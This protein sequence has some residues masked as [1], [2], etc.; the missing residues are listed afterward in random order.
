MPV[1]RRLT[2]PFGQLVLVELR[3][4]ET[5]EAFDEASASLLADLPKSASSLRRTN[6]L[7]GRLALMEALRHAGAAPHPIGQSARGAPIVPLGF[8]GSVSHKRL[9]RA[10]GPSVVAAALVAKVEP[11]Q[12]TVGVDLETKAPAR[13]DIASRILTAIEQRGL[14]G[15]EVDWPRV[16]ASFSVKE[17]I[18]KAVDPL[19]QRYVAF[20]EAELTDVPAHWPTPGGAFVRALLA[21]RR[22]EPSFELEAFLQTPA[23]DPDLLVSAVRATRRPH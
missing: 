17:S 5:D 11:G 7:A 3:L 9:R 12:V 1:F 6:Y 13:P 20:S 19:L 21:R 18:Y 8:S 22:G 15:G 16:L 14:V 23:E 2:H 10:E 4:D